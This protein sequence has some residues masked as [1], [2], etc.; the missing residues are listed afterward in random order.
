MFKN[1]ER[2]GF[3]PVAYRQL[4]QIFMTPYLSDVNQ[5]L[6]IADN[7]FEK[8]RKLGLDIRNAP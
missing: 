5:N 6:K 8:S 3:I 1:A 4:G 7:Y 2:L